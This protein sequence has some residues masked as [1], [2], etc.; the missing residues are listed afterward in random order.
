MYADV[1]PRT[2]FL[3]DH[4]FTA[5]EASLAAGAGGQFALG[6]SAENADQLADVDVIVGYGDE[7]LHA[8]LQADPL[9]NTLPAVQNGAVVTL[10]GNGEGLAAASSP[11]ALSIPWMLDEYVGLLDDAVAKAE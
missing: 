8:A 11:T 5:P 7:D 10:G 4:G 1:G 3:P 6:V 9:W 2:A